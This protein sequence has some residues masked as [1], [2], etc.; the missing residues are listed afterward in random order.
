MSLSITVHEFPATPGLQLSPFGLK[1][2]TWLK[3]MGLDY[4]VHWTAQEMGP[5]GKVPYATVNGHVLGDSECIID[6]IT[7][8]F[9]VPVPPA[10]LLSDVEK[11]RGVM[12]RRLIEEHLY[13]IMVYSR[14]S[15][16]KNW[17]GFKEIF[18]APAPAFLRGFISKKVRKKVQA[19]LVAQ[20]IAR[21]TME[22]IYK[23]ADIDLRALSVLLNDN[24]YF[25][26]NAPTLTDASAYGLLANLYYSPVNNTVT[27]ALEKHDNLVAYVK[28]MKGEFWP[29]S[30]RGGGDEAS[31]R[32][33]VDQQLAS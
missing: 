15:D 14:W 13:F 10:F 23:K 25:H 1:L 12:I 24:L 27:D 17:P 28:R 4:D 8:Q 18:F 21:H 33:V 20:G 26:G 16:E 5:K 22:E 32:H 7:D 6:Y 3:M 30:I 19:N 31:Y 11:A 9:S 29:Q 2:E